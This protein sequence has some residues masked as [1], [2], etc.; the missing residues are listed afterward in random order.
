[1][2]LRL[3]TKVGQDAEL[4]D[5][6]SRASLPGTLY[7]PSADHR[8]HLAAACGSGCVTSLSI[9]FGLDA[10]IRLEPRAFKPELQRHILTPA[11]VF[12]LHN[13]VPAH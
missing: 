12:A 4:C 6:G 10:L 7:L 5:L 9:L 2:D 13:T 1:M 3:L 8:Q 11:L